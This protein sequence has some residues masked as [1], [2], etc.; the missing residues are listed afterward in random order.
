MPYRILPHYTTVFIQLSRTPGKLA[1]KVDL[2]AA[3]G[4]NER[5]QGKRK[6]PA[7]GVASKDR[8]GQKGSAT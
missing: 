2:G 4:H 5:G 3:L 7:A 1:F 8:Q 6:A